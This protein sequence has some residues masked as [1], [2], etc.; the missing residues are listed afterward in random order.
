MRISGAA[1]LARLLCVSLF[2]L[3]CL[4]LILFHLPACVCVTASCFLPLIRHISAWQKATLQHIAASPLSLLLVFLL[5]FLF[6]R[7]FA[8]FAKAKTSL[9]DVTMRE[10]AHVPALSESKLAL[11][12]SRCLLTAL[13]LN[14]FIAAQLRCWRRRRRCRRRFYCP[15]KSVCA[16]CMRFLLA[17]CLLRRLPCFLTLLPLP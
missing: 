2:R 6:A 14:I 13:L 15:V 17:L 9:N 11:S 16:K 4:F 1:S 5:R 8:F 3:F 10:P 7:T 12:L